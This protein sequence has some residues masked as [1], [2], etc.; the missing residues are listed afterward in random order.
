MI[1][2]LFKGKSEKTLDDALAGISASIFPMGESDIRRD[3]ERVD[4]LTN[5]KLPDLDLRAFVTG[6]K[7]LVAI[8]SSY[9]D[10][11]FIRSFIARSKNRINE[12]EARDVYVYL[13]GESIYRARM[14]TVIRGGGSNA[15]SASLDFLD[16][17]GKPWRS[18]T[19]KDKIPGGRGEFGLCVD[20]PVPTVCVNGSNVYLS[21]LR[22]NGS[23]VQSQR[24]G[25]TST[26][27]TVGNVDIYQLSQS[28]TDLPK[29]Y[30]CPYHRKD[31]KVAPI[32]FQL[33]L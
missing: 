26:P 24:L 20:N 13:A 32:G 2:G 12:T 22:V 4:I 31:S 9:D 27:V 8:N 23:P 28:G 1:W 3:C 7:T 18:G 33:Q 17:I 11:G 19:E 15:T 6:S 16:D 5:A 14:V 10:E 25:S 21:R 29:V 30:I